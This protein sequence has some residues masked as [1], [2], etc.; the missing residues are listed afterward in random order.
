MYRIGRLV[1]FALL[2]A[3]CD[4]SSSTP[5]RC[6]VEADCALGERC[7]DGRC[8]PLGDAGSDD[9]GTDGGAVDAPAD[10]GPTCPTMV[11]CGD[12]PVCCAEGSECVDGRCL[13]VCESGVRCGADRETCCGAGQVCVSAACVDP[14]AECTDSF[15]CPIGDFCEPTLGRCLRQFDPVECTVTPEFLDLDVV[16]EWSAQT[17]TEVPDCMHAISS[18][19]VVDLDE[20]G[21]PEVIVNFACDDSWDRGVIRAFNGATGAP[22]WTQGTHQTHGR[23]GIAAGDLDNDGRAEIVGVG[24]P[25]SGLARLFALDDDGSLLWQATIADGSAQ[26]RVNPANG[27]PTI[28]DLDGDGSPEVL[29]GAVVYDA[30]GRLLWERDGGAREGTNDGYSGGIVAVADLDGDGVPE[31][32]TGRRAYRSDGT[33]FWE[34]SRP[35]GAVPDGYPAIGQFDED[36]Q[37]EVVLVAS[38]SVYLLDGLTGEVQWG[39]HVLPNTPGRIRGR[40]GPPTIADFDGDGQREIGVAGASAYVVFD[41]SREEPILWWQP[42]EDVSSHATGSSVFDFDGDGVAEVIYADECYVRVYRGTDGEVLLRIPNSTATIHEYP[43]VADVDADGRSEIV[44]V[45]NDRTASLRTQCRNADATWDGARRGVFVYGDARNEWMRTRRVWNQHT[46][47]VTNVTNVAGR[48]PM[49]E[50]NNWED[51]RLNN[52][53]QNVQGEGVFNAPDLVVLALEVLL[54]GCPT[55]ATLRARVGNEGSLGVEAGVSVTFRAGTPAAPGAVLG[56]ATTTV[57][58]LPGASTVVT[59]SGVALEGA[60]PYSFFATVD[61]DGTGVGVIVECNTDN[62]R[63]AIGDISCDLLI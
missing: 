60:P 55:S 30:M 37:P 57:P 52:Y 54:D 6:E 21:R 3:A 4:C 63:A 32:I 51:E 20:D 47:H 48:I 8:V 2:L 36:P 38:G 59:L 29:F 5:G 33:P 26:H 16:L 34:A 10:S 56:T 1:S 19:V 49:S 46:Y 39:P 7:I 11:I 15:D 42:T 28:A 40:G 12:P 13:D 31:V 53:R 17:A 18:P 23:I 22:V 41:P 9:G 58:L 27:A 45:A 14:G 44:V 61:D 25:A 43:L 62:N 50:A 24:R 35:G